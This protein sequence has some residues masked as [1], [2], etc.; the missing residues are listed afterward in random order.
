MVTDRDWDGLLGKLPGVG[1]IRLTRNELLLLDWVLCLQSGLMVAVAE[2]IVGDWHDFRMRVWRGVL[3]PGHDTEAEG[4][5]FEVDETDAIVLLVVL[6]TSFNWGAEDC[7]FS[8]KVKL[9]TSLDGIYQDPIIEREAQGN[10][11]E[12]ATKTDSDAKGEAGA[13]AGDIPR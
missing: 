10:A 2:D 4:V 12:N 11:G 9:A 6:P 3:D 13:A 5:L 7:G 1:A 8:L